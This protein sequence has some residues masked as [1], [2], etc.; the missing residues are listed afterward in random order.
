MHPKLL[1]QNLKVSIKKDMFTKP[2]LNLGKWSTGIGGTLKRFHDCWQKVKKTGKEL[3]IDAFDLFAF[4]PIN[5]DKHDNDFSFWRLWNTAWVVTKISMSV[6]SFNSTKIAP[7]LKKTTFEIKCS[8]PQISYFS[9]EKLPLIF[10]CT[11]P[12]AK[13]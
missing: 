10:G 13:L 1:K 7:S 9:S 8:K 11:C 3:K 4:L 2:K 12:I 6:P 5:P